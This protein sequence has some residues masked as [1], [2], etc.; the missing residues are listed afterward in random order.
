MRIK[1]CGLTRYE[2]AKLAHNL[3]AWAL[4]FIFYEGSKRC[5]TTD[6]AETVL[7]QLPDNARRVG[8]FVNQTD[9]AI[10]LAQD[11]P[12]QTLQLHGD[13]TPD[14]CAKA[15]A[16]GLRTIKALRPQTPDDID[17]AKNYMDAVDYILID[18][19]GAGYGGSGKT[20]D[21]SLARRAVDAGLPV[22][23]AGGLKA[24]NILAAADTN[25]YALDLA[26]GVEMAPGIKDH[27]KM[28]TLFTTAKGAAP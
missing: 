12:L 13:E 1:I 5:I 8:V 9:D 4:G 28:R 22:I 6:A 25:V 10:A 27:D 2:D 16:T 3:G 23:L 20:A 15:R 19:A 11:L 17:G 7:T 21:W 26:G 24:D 18:T 14:D